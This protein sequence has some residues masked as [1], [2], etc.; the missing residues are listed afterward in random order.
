MAL[1]RLALILAIPVCCL[2]GCQKEAIDTRVQDEDAIRAADAATLKAAQA[3]DVNGA[4]VNYA[5]NSFWLPPNAPMISGK[6][7][8][9]EGW[10]KSVSIPGFNIAI[11]K[12]G[13]S[14]RLREVERAPE[15]TAF[16]VDLF[17][18]LQDGIEQR[19]RARWA[20]GHVNVHGNDLIHA[21]HDGVVVE[22]TAGSGASPH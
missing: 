6:A 20:A 7:A 10:A 13:L 3:K 14:A 9:R 1:N 8:I 22:N 16:G 21:L 12:E 4:I 18:K 17:L 5:D 11:R 15:R 19:L 2:Y